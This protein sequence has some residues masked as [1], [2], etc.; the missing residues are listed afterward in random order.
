MTNAAGAADDAYM[1][2]SHG[3]WD[4]HREAGSSSSRTRLVSMLCWALRAVLVIGALYGVGMLVLLFLPSNVA[5]HANIATDS[6]VSLL[7][8]LG[9]SVAA[10]LA[11]SCIK[12]WGGRVTFNRAVRRISTAP[13][14]ERSAPM[15]VSDMPGSA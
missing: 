3:K 12:V 5:W 10:L 15:G 4:S 13:L 2:H 14:A 1:Y 9:L 6:G 7:F 11:Y 8:A